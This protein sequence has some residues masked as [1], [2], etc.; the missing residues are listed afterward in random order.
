MGEG[1]DLRLAVMVSGSGSNLQA[2]LDAIAEGSLGARVEAV[3]CNRRRA[4]ALERA[5]CA[6]V[7]TVYV[8]FLPYRRGIGTTWPDEVAAREAYDRDVAAR[9]AALD[10]DLV[11]CAGWMHILGPAFFEVDGVPPLIN[12]HPALPGAYPGADAVGQALQAFGRG[13][14]EGTGC[15]VH[16][17]VP[18]VD[19]GP[20]LGQTPLPFQ[21]GETRA[22]FAPRLHAAEHRLLLDVLR[23]LASIP[24]D[25]LPGS[26]T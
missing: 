1:R 4:Y 23:R 9:L 18:E 7:D 22:S 2:I 13:E 17:V 24:I 20:V 16:V 12:L 6:G 26:L 10:V 21:P 5:R 25:E 19:A 14:A 8:P 15:M 11:V 3:V